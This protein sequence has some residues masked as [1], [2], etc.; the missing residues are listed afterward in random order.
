MAKFWTTLLCFSFVEFRVSYLDFYVGLFFSPFRLIDSFAPTHKISFSV[1]VITVLEGTCVV[2]TRLS[3]LFSNTL[4]FALLVVCLGRETRK[5][6]KKKRKDD[7]DTRERKRFAL[8]LS[9]F[10][11]ARTFFLLSHHI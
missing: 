6:K 2:L 7:E 8:C 11:V 3:F 5:E 9:L 10:V 1:Q 4:C